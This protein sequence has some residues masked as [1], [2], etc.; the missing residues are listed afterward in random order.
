MPVKFKP[1]KQF[2]TVDQLAERWECA[3]ADIEH[4]IEVKDLKP[5]WRRAAI[6][7]RDALIFYV[8]GSKTA[9]DN[10]LA[11]QVESGYTRFDVLEFLGPR[12]LL[13]VE[14]QDSQDFCEL[15]LFA[16][17]GLFDENDLV[18]TLK[19]RSKDT[20]SFRATFLVI[21]DWIE[22]FQKDGSM[23]LVITESEVS[24]FEREHGEATE[25]TAPP[26]SWPWGGHK[27]PLLLIL[28]DAVTEFCLDGPE[29]YPKKGC[30][31]VVDWIMARMEA[32]GMKPSKSL[33]GAM[34]TLISPRTYVHHRQRIQRK[35]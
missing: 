20:R 28:A 16:G 4:L 30:G 15:K 11:E 23:D 10:A 9:Y 14:D 8:T 3:K 34:E 25:D 35:P 21:R 5:I 6:K 22:S 7:G 2:Y 13:Y 27:T 33:A 29:H 12:D 17:P 1:P 18:K 19:A 31:E 32:N 24:R 26:S